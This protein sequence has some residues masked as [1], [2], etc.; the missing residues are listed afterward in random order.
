ML[1]LLLVFAQ[2]G[3]V[4]HE[5]GHLSQGQRSEGATLRADAQLLE[6]GVCLTC[7]AFAQV[8]NP[9]AGGAPS[10]AA[11][12]AAVIPAPE[13]CYIVVGA[14]APTPRSRGPPQV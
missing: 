10:L 12:P 1:L 7:E 13:P 4:L 11:C 14:D 2:Y 5:L 9:A 6:N 8:A 3:A